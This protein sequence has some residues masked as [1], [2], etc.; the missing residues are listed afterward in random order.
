ME[1]CLYQSVIR[2]SSFKAAK[3][4]SI[5]NNLISQ[6]NIC[7]NLTFPLSIIQPLLQAYIHI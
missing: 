7:L 2:E 5:L 4:Q 6:L 1:T 3:I